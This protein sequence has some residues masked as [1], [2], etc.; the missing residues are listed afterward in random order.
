MEHKLIYKLKSEVTLH[1]LPKNSSALGKAKVVQEGKDIT[2]ASYSN[3]V[4]TVLNAVKDDLLKDYSV[5]VSYTH[6]TLPTKR[7]V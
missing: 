5:A 1:P 4:N 3:M 7:I 2:V 6:L